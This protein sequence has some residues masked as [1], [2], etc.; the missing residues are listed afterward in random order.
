MMMKRIFPVVLITL[1]I[2]LSLG[3]LSQLYWSNR[4]NSAVSVDLPNQLAGLR[5]TDSQ[6]GADA[7]AEITAL[8]GKEFPVDFGAIGIYGNRE[9]TLWVAGTPSESIAVEMT[10]AM[11]QKIAK[12]NSPFTP[13]NEINYRKSKIYAL[14]GMGQ[15]HYY[16]QSK[17]LVIWLAVD[18]VFA[19]EALQQILEVYS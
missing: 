6:S 9:I 12:G 1:G 7:I 15:S 17:A 4:E 3:A 2:L 13:I 10:N 19:D 11:Q 5:I 14:K 18:P 16:F 8:H